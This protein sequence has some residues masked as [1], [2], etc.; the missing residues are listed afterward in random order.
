[1]HRTKNTLGG[2]SLNC[3]RKHRKKGGGERQKGEDRIYVWGLL[4]FLELVFG[5]NAVAE[6]K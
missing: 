1:M 4:F 5:G 3:T 2:G 6:G